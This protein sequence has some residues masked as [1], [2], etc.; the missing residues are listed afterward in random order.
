MFNLARSI[1]S[2]S[3]LGPLAF[4]IAA[5][6]PS[7]LFDNRQHLAGR[8]LDVSSI[9]AHGELVE[10]L[11]ER[12]GRCSLSFDRLRMRGVHYRLPLAS[13]Q[14]SSPTLPF[15]HVAVFGS[16]LRICFFGPNLNDRLIYN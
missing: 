14:A 16:R 15:P 12:Q 4:Q 6:H 13:G 5:H 8:T 3:N 9:P 2:D 1:F 7:L 10:P 11:F